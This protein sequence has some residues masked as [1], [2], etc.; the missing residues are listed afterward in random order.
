MSGRYDGAEL[1]R[2]LARMHLAEP[3]DP[4]ALAGKFGFSVE[5]TIGGTPQPNQW[6]DSWIE[7][8]RERRLRHQVKLANDA[9]LS[10][11][12]DKICAGMEIFFDGITVRPS[13]LH[14][15]LWSGNIAGVDGMPCIF[16]PATYYGHHEAEFGMSWCAGFGQG[17]WDSYHTVIP[18]ERGWEVRHDLYTLYHY[19]NHYNLFGHSYYRQCIQIMERLVAKL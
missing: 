10:R 19:L 3:S 4:T 5:N 14:G 8:F 11:L 9:R 1:G 18:R 12:G 15:D 2:Q 13:V 17:F 7:F 6:S 16:D